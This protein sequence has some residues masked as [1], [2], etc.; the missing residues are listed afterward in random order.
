[1]IK[2]DNI[3]QSIN[4]SGPLKLIKDIETRWNSTYLMLRRVLQLKEAVT[5]ALD[6]MTE[7]K[8]IK[9]CWEDLADI[10]KFL[11]PFY[12]ITNKISSGSTSTMSI[13]APVV[14]ILKEELSCHFNN[15]YLDE[16]AQN[17]VSKITKYEDKLI[18]DLTITAA[19]LD[20]RIKN[21]FL[22][23][24][25]RITAGDSLRNQILCI[26]GENDQI[27]TPSTFNSSSYSIE[28]DLL[29]KIYTNDESDEVERYLSSG[30][31]SSSVDI[32]AYWRANK[33]C[34]PTLYK[35]AQI[36]LSAQSTSV[37]SER[38]FS[39]AGEIDTP[40]RNKLSDESF[41]ANM[42]LNSWIPFLDL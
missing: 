27:G 20:P 3:Q 14:P 5:R 31:E 34:Y 25:T 9:I 28:E 26:N 24:S 33:G 41:R 10:V 2:F 42:L 4:D 6:L 18:N 37:P 17:F 8:N 21:T 30:V 23:Q 38:A 35:L 36:V 22:P 39:L 32:S 19:L 16:A 1:M 7:L 29:S 40:R 12:D 13:V 15:V 11:K